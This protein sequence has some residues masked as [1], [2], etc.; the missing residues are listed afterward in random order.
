MNLRN[1]GDIEDEPIPPRMT[2]QQAADVAGVSLASWSGRVARGTAPGPVLYVD[3]VPMWGR[4]E[5]LAWVQQ[6]T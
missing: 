1:V 3:D 2:K 5:V 4:D 6:Q